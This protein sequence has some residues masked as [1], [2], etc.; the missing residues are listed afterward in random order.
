[1]L[2]A[3]RRHPPADLTRIRAAPR[4]LCFADDDGVPVEI[5]ILD[6]QPQALH[7]AHPRAVQKA[8]EQRVFIGQVGEDGGDLVLRE[9]GGNALLVGGPLDAVQPGQRGVQHLS[10]EEQQR[11][12]RLVVRGRRDAPLGGQHRE[13]GLDML[14]AHVARMLHAVPTDEEPDPVNV[15]LLGTE[16]IVQIARTLP[17]L[18]QQARGS[19]WWD[20][21]FHGL[22]YTCMNKQCKARKPSTQATQR[23]TAWPD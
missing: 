6:A 23:R 21:G 14:G 7:Q 10:I 1:M 18:V 19:Q 22:I 3:R 17:D 13:E 15:Q 2:P 4:A 8:R 12:Q 16:A 9:D 11:A 5:D 20:A